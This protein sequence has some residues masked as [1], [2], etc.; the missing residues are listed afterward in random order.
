MWGDILSPLGVLSALKDIISALEVS[1]KP[2]LHV[3][4]RLAEHACDD[5]SKRILKSSTYRLQMFLVRDQ[6]LR[7]LLPHED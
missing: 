6:Y 3:V 1:V 5:A 2:G 4:V 7:S